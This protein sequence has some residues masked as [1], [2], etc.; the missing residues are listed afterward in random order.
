MTYSD[1]H[2]KC[3]LNLYYRRKEFHM[4]VSQIASFCKI[5]K[6]DIYNWRGNCNPNY[7]LPKENK[8]ILTSPIQLFIIESIKTNCFLTA[9]QLRSSIIYS[10]NVP[11]SKSTINNFLQKKNYTYKKAQIHKTRFLPD[12]LLLKETELIADISKNNSNNIISIDETSIDLNSK[13]AYGRSLKNEKCTYVSHNIK[14]KRKTLLLAISRKKIIKFKIV[15]G[16]ING[17]IYKTFIQDINR[18]HTDSVL[19]MDN[20]RIHHYKKLKKYMETKKENNNRIVYNIPYNPKTNP[21]EYLFN[22]LKYKLNQMNITEEN[23]TK[24]IQSTLKQL[25]K[26]GFDCYFDKS[27]KV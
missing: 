2:R 22:S 26:N 19:L 4:S 25:N 14:R 3:I 24:S 10:F 21:I 6:Q 16:S 8:S 23:L 18:K 11:I 5:S 7:K 27:F 20:A 1:D 9:R 17:E 12:D 13:P 15:N